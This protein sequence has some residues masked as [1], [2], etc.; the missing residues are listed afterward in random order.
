MGRFDKFDAQA[1]A[2]LIDGAGARDVMGCLGEAEA[3]FP[4]RL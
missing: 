3:R 1:V 2:G 4:S